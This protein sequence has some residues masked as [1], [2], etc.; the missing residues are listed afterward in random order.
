[1]KSFV[2]TLP[3][4]K[5]RQHH[6]IAMLGAQGIEFEF[7][8]AVDGRTFDVPSHPVYNVTKRRMFFGRDMTGGEIGVLLSHRG[9][10]QKMVDEAIDLALV[11]EDDAVVNDDFA[12]VVQALRDGQQDF[13]LIRFL[14]S[15]KNARVKQYIKRPLLGEYVISRM[16]TTPGGAHAYMITL[17]GAR[18]MLRILSRVYL[19]I[20][21]L[22]GHN[23]LNGLRAYMVQKPGFAM[24]DAQQDQFIGEA[25]FDKTVDLSPFMALIFPLTRAWFK[26]YEGVM[27]RLWYF[28]NKY[29]DQA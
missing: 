15:K 23:W 6:M 18:K 29:K 1:M 13:E 5:G 21:T 20:D 16:Q 3:E 26:I 2:I 7:F 14:G 9:I 4:A 12:A 27:K 11:F 10:Y 24:Q 28:K 22:Q 25:R 8:E 19:P 17:E